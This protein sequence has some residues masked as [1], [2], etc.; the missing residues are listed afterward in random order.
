MAS[1]GLD[2]VEPEGKRAQARLMHFPPGTSLYR[3]GANRTAWY[4]IRRGFVLRRDGAGLVLRAEGLAGPGEVLGLESPKVSR[5]A[6]SAFALSAIDVA[7][8][9]LPALW[10]C[11][12]LLARIVAGPQSV[13]CLGHWKRHMRWTS[14]PPC[15][16][17]AASLQS[18]TETARVECIDLAGASL[19]APDVA[20]WLAL[21]LEAALDAMEHLAQH[22]TLHLTG[23][24]A[25]AID[26]AE[27]LGR[28]APPTGADVALS[29][30]GTREQRGLDAS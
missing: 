6:E 12:G 2:V 19:D 14:L 30:P 15:E 5:H 28:C 25:L 13:A 26:T 16:R 10:S 8:I 11:P 7:V 4:L 24:A 20:H 17:L 21:P 18:L 9:D 1:I 3:A 23:A 29:H 27:L 22:D